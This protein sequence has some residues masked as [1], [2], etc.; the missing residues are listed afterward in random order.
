MGLGALAAAVGAVATGTIRLA[1]GDHAAATPLAAPPLIV[2]PTPEIVSDPGGMVGI[3]PTR[4]DPATRLHC[5]GSLV[6]PSWVLTAAHCVTS[7]LPKEVEVIAGTLDLGAVGER[8]GVTAIVCHPRWNAATLEGDAALLRL[9]RPLNQPTMLLA[10]ER[11]V[12][13]RARAGAVVEVSGW[14][15]R[16]PAGPLSRVLLRSR[17]QI[18]ERGTCASRMTLVPVTQAMLCAGDPDFLRDACKHDSGG[19]LTVRH[20]GTTYQIGI[21][22]WGDGCAMRDRYGVYTRV[23]VVRPWIDTVIGGPASAWSGA[24]VHEVP[25]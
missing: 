12:S 19:P 4:A 20:D 16:R 22:S 23:D 17:L 9:Q 10:D 2:D 1:S 13:E 24:C 7:T 18:V 11:I 14:G 15:T 8:V 3:L 5:G 25:H 21:V 6:A